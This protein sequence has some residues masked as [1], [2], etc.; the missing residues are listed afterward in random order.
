[1]GRLSGAWV[2]GYGTGRGR[3]AAR[4]ATGPCT[5]NVGSAWVVGREFSKHPPWSIAMSTSTDPGFIRRTRS[6]ETS[7]G[8]FAPGM[9]TAPITRSG[10][11]HGLLDR[12]GGRVERDRKSTRLNSSHVKISYAVFCL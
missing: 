8:A 4:W 5:W 12:V 1:S 11:E 7:L 10:L 9:S 6:S 3:V 2:G